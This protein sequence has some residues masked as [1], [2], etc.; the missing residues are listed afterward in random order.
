[1]LAFRPA[2]PACHRE[3]EAKAIHASVFGR[4][5]PKKHGVLVEDAHLRAL[6]DEATVQR[7]R[8][9][10][11]EGVAGA[12]A[13]PACATLMR[14]IEVQHVPARGCP[15]CHAL[16]F[17][18]EAIQL[19]VLGVRRRQH[20]EGSFAGRADVSRM[21]ADLQPTEVIA[22]LLAYF[23]MGSDGSPPMSA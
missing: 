12:V 10:I 14:G 16:W 5:C 4:A 1:M 13:C 23:G 22:G 7:L 21:G 17:S 15:A 6:A 2:C 20:G 19:H 11:T 9:L 3:L 8:G 18:E